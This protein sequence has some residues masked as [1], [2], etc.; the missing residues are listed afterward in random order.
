MDEERENLS[1]PEE[2]KADEKAISSDLIRGHIS[3]IILRSLYDGDKYGYE[4]IAEIER[5]SHGQY[6]MKQPS[7]YSALKRLESQ[8]YITSYWGGSVDGGRR[9]YFSL[10]DE[11]RD[12]SERNQSEWEYSR[13]VIDSLISEKQFDFSNP[14]PTLVDM[15]VLKKSTTRI[16][17]RED[18][19][20]EL[21]YASGISEEEKLRF[22]EER[23]RSEAS[24]AEERAALEEER[25]RFEE[26]LQEKQ[27]LLDEEKLTAEE[28]RAKLVAEIKEK[29]IALDEEKARLQEELEQKQREIEMERERLASEQRFQEEQARS[30]QE[31]QS[32]L[33]EMQRDVQLR[34]EQEDA[35]R[36]EELRQ[37]EQEL[38]EQRAFTAQRL[39]EREQEMKEERAKF[40]QMLLE[41]DQIIAAQ[42]EQYAVELEEQTRLVRE[43]QAR[44]FAAREKQLIHQ[45]Y[46][47]LVNTP[48]K[49]QTQD[50]YNYYTPP[51]AED[52]PKA[53]PLSASEEQS[54]RSVVQKLYSNSIRSEQAVDTQEE[55]PQKA[56]S[57]GRIDFYDLEERATQDGIKIST[58][59]GGNKQKEGKSE[60][61]VHKGKAL[62]FSAIAV[63]L[64]C[65]AEGSILLA[66]TEKLAIPTA[67]PYIIYA[68]GIATVLVCALAYANH[69]GERALRQTGNAL[70]NAFVAFVLIS[71]F[72]LVLALALKIDFTNLS[73]LTCYVFIPVVLA[74]NIVIF[75]IAYVAQVKRK[76]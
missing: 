36:A 50:E 25:L 66:L 13:T 37:K 47:N 75:A 23:L 51:L 39:Q 68:L 27:R 63:F 30:F 40:E 26:E 3:T 62:F 33:E 22:E 24:L 65:L 1:L 15:R 16:P 46:L 52:E 21:D 58:S 14:A 5:K 56:Q 9:K 20:D 18:G 28:E 42:R 48:P 72:A 44:E 19:M 64:F 67:Y 35:Q 43:Q 69:F 55:L 34:L 41:R 10:T 45:N 76:K 4:I 7:L 38:E 32:A 49:T 74:F 60:S 73:Q 54:Y 53:S 6:S 61:I 70:L 57:L 71:I 29:E 59:G 17:D 8:G 11:G 12:V 31:E 2:E